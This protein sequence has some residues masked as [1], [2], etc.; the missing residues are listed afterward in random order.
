ML[1]YA[2]NMIRKLFIDHYVS[3]QTLIFPQIGIANDPK[4][5][6]GATAVVASFTRTATNRRETRYHV[7]SPRSGNFGAVTQYEVRA[8]NIPATVFSA[9]VFFS[10]DQVCHLLPLP[11]LPYKST[12]NPVL[13]P[14]P[15]PR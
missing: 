2:T 6:L 12:S 8:V 1:G 4:N 10:L 9:Q 13:R 14:R 3:D 11:F 15:S 5:I 7:R